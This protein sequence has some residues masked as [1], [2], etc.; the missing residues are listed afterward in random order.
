MGDMTLWADPRTAKP[1]RIELDMPA[2]KAHGVLDSFHY[3]APLD[4]SLFSV[5]VPM[6]YAQQTMNVGVPLEQGLID[7][8]R[9][10]AKQRDGAFPKKL[11]INREVMEALQAIAGPDLGAMA[12]S[13]DEDAAEVVMSALP[14]EQKY[15]EG[16]LFY[17][18]L[19]P[20]NKAHYAGEGVKLDTPNRPIF[21][22]RPTGAE[23][24]RVIYADLH[25]QEM[26]PDEVKQLS[27]TLGK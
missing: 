19:K 9:A 23:Q 12:A 1:I 20:E 22:Y 25:V 26:S 8:L 13:G 2:M 24:F 10:V 7:T 3:D 18:S 14:F 27:A 16:I 4:P 5:A 11:G 21:W 17:M 15:M 6:G